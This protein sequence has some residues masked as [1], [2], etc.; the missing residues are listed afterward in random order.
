MRQEIRNKSKRSQV[1]I[2][3]IIA[4]AIVAVLLVVYFPQLKKIIIPAAPSEY[5]PLDCIEKI[6]NGNLGK[7]MLRGGT[8]N[9][10]LNFRYNNISIAYIC[11][12]SEWYKTCT[13]QKPFLKTSAE[14]ELEVI[15]QA[16][17]AKCINGM[18]DRL[19][20]KGYS[21]KTTGSKSAKISIM[22]EKIAVEFNMTMALTKGE[23]TSLLSANQFKANINSNS[24]DILMIA[25]SIQNFE[26][27]FGDANIE[28][29]MTYY[30]NLKVEKKRQSDGTKV[31]IIT[32]RNTKE[33][34]QF[35][36]RSLAWPPG[37]ALPVTSTY[38]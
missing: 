18:E 22:P 27:R 31:Y 30:P 38:D 28:D 35:A 5:V 1:T 36:T 14:K 10:E 34:L 11:Y 12:T 25:S 9:P 3:V 24:Y 33:V 20:A 8:M 7:I 19:K 16:E 23:E 26:A 2:F 21:V 32:D 13:M 6:V 4:I 15:S 37:F 29:Y 17:I